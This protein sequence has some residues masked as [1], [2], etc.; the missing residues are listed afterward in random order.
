M[1]T[2]SRPRQIKIKNHITSS[3]TKRRVGMMVETMDNNQVTDGKK[4][5]E[6]LRSLRDGFMEARGISKN[7]T[8]VEDILM[9]RKIEK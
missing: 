7:G 8:R 2:K 9:V 4:A 1:I 5:A 6:A 3:R